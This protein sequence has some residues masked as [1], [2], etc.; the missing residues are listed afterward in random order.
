MSFLLDTQESRRGLIW[1]TD[2][3]QGEDGIDSLNEQGQLM[4]ASIT[5]RITDII[6]Q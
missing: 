2:W 5:Q 1:T 6:N 3:S 4:L